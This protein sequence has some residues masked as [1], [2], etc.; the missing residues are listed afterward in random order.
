MSDCIGSS[1]TRSCESAPRG[2]KPRHVKCLN[3]GQ[4]ILKLDVANQP[5]CFATSNRALVVEQSVARIPCT[6]KKD[7]VRKW[8]E[9]HRDG[10]SNLSDDDLPEIFSSQKTPTSESSPVL[11]N[12]GK[13]RDKRGTRKNKNKHTVTRSADD[14]N[15]QEQDA[16]YSVNCTKQDS[17]NKGENQD[18]Q[19]YLHKTQ[20]TPSCTKIIVDRSPVLGTGLYSHKRRRRKLW[21]GTEDHVSSKRLKLD[22]DKITNVEPD[23]N[24]DNLHEKSIDHIV[25]EEDSGS[26][27]KEIVYQ[28]ETE[29]SPERLKMCTS[30]SQTPQR[31]SS[32]DSSS[33]KNNKVNLK[34]KIDSSDESNEAEYNKFSNTNSSTNNSL[35]NIVEEVDTQDMLSVMRKTQFSSKSLFTSRSLSKASQLLSN[36]SN[37]TYCSEAEMLQ[38][39]STHLSAKISLVPSLT[40][41]VTSSKSTQTPVI[42]TIST[43]S[44][45]SP[46]KAMYARLLDSGKKNHKAKKGS[47]VAKLQSLINTQV[48]SIR[49]WRHRMNKKHEAAS[50]RF[51]SV[52]VRDCSKRFGN[53]FLKGTLIEDRFNLL[54]NDIEIGEAESCNGQTPARKNSHRDLTIILVCDIVGT[55]KMISEVVI[56]VYPPWDILDKVDLTLEAMYIS[57]S[58]EMPNLH[59]DKD[60]SR[61]RKKRVV[62]EFNCPCIREN[63]EFSFCARKPSADKPD[64]MQ[65]I[66]CL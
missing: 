63:R 41:E 33:H 38:D 6:E 52:L 8:I 13:R 36:D 42:S 56:N 17:E 54:Q 24:C 20:C 44:K 50:A 60:N 51:I 32:E 58:H 27:A 30:L 14:T 11:G 29:E 47:M 26:S 9:T 2:G 21:Y 19:E 61:K 28:I 5:S 62:K 10:G 45:T 66:F 12:I 57:I 3:F 40:R 59:P 22:Y 4:S 31:S 16:Q 7:Y 18:K 46:D 37:E 64:V 65:Q 34:M 1:S 43:P 25:L 23:S 53:Q 48:S 39:Q 49:I 55:L 35:S 15:G